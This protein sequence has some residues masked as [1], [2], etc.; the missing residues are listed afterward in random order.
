[1]IYEIPKLPDEV[2]EAVN[3]NR[4]AVFVGAGASRLIGCM[5]WDQ[6]A[7]NLVNRCFSTKKKDGSGIINYKEKETLIQD[8]DHK[9]TI[10]KC[11]YLLKKNGFENIFYK[12]L[13][14]SLKAD[15]KLI[16]SQN[17]YNELY[18]LRGLFITTNADEHFD[19]KFE[20]TRIVW[21]EEDFNPS[22]IDRTKIYH[23]HGSIKDKNSLVFTVHQYINRYNNQTFKMFLEKIF[24]E[25]IV[26]FVGYGM[27]EFELLDFLITKYDPNKKQ[28]PK[29]FILLPFY[30]GE[31]NILEFEQYYYNSM[32]IRVLPYA[33]DN[34]GYGQ[35][36]DVIKS[37]N[38]EINQVSTYLYDSY[39]E[40]EDAANNYSEEKAERIFQIIKN[41]ESQRI[42][43]FNKLSSSPNPFP[44][45]KPLKEKGYFDPQHNPPPQKV[46]DNKGYFTFPYW[47]VLGYLKNVAY[48]I[49]ENPDTEVIETLL[50]I[51]NKIITYQDEKGERIENYET[52]MVMIK[53]IF[54]LPINKITENHIDFMR[55]ALT[56]KWD[57]TLIAS[58]VGNT[59]LPK[60]LQ[61]KAENLVLNL[62]DI[63]LSYKKVEEKSYFDDKKTYEYTSIMDEYWLKEA[64]QNHKQ[65][66]A[67][68]CGIDAAR[69]AIG[70]IKKILE[71]DNIWIPTIE[72]HPQTNFPDRYEC[73]LVH[74]VRDMF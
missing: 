36:Y 48:K 6:L 68:L 8:K 34:K 57:N 9:K 54:S 47:N 50:E 66:I 45:L 28:N 21:R 70:K 14:K 53:I 27:A 40:I 29:H 69:I 72:D 37:W 23:I 42:Y 74:F 22:K 56:S 73:Q 61:E 3:N 65:K 71:E 52:D 43:F 13:K 10:T 67:E 49:K 20:P 51:V 55:L 19:N 16:K 26:L 31:E 17:I 11:Y 5:G 2:K 7:C 62:L 39:Q 60:L 4:L 12:E 58:E 35:L 18:R 15:K 38:R 30:K 41:D 1:M 64:L 44:W 25:Y 59:V 33:K 24:R 32:G 63:I 46:P